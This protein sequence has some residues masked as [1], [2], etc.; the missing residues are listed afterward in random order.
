MSRTAATKLKSVYWDILRKKRG[1]IHASGIKKNGNLLYTLV[2]M[3]EV[4]A[5]YYERQLTALGRTTER[6]KAQIKLSAQQGA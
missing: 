2:P 6:H 5:T 3:H 1:V 4:I